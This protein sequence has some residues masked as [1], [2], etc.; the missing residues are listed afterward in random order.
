MKY[1]IVFINN[2]DGFKVVSISS[3]DD[4]ETQ[5]QQ[6]KIFKDRLDEYG[7]DW[8]GFPQVEFHEVQEVNEI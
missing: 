8:L 2:L 4:Y 3:Y 7:F 5:Q 1:Y 6:F